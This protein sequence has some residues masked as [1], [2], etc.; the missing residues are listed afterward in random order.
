MVA[1]ALL[2]GLAGSATA[3]NVVVDDDRAECPAAG[4]TSVQAGVNAASSGDTVVICPG[5]Y[6]EGS[7]MPGTNAVTVDKEIDIR[8]AG[9]D[10]VTIMPKRSTASGGQIASITPVLRDPVGAIIAVTAGT[11]L[12]P[13]DVDISGVT[14]KGN[15]VFS[16]AGILYLDAKGKIFRSRVTD[17]VSSERAEAYDIPGGFRSSNTGYGIVQ[18]TAAATPPA[19]GSVPRTLV[20]ESTRVDKYN[21]TGILIDGATGDSLPLT[22]A[23]VNN[24]ADIVASM[25][26]GRLRCI[27]F[28]S[29]GNCATVGTLT[30]GPLFGQDGLRVTAGASVDVTSSSFFQNY[31]NGTGAPVFNSAT[32]NANLSQAAGVRLIGAAPSTI[33]GSNIANNHFGAFNV[34]LDG[35]TANTAAPLS[36][37]NNWWGLRT[38]GATYNNGPAISP[39]TNPPQYENPVNGTAVAD[40]SCVAT[41]IQATPGPDTTVSNSDTVDFCP[42]RNGAQV[43]PAKGEQPILDA[44]LPMSDAGPAIGLSLDKTGYDRGD[45]AVLTANA[46]DDFAVAK[47]TFYDGNEVIGTSTLPPYRSEIQIPADAACASRTLSAIVEDST[48]QTEIA[49]TTLSVTGP[50]DCEEIP[51][52]PDPPALPTIDLDV[53][54]TIGSAG[55]KATAAVTAE[56]GAQSVVFYLGTKTICTDS[57]APFECQ[58]QPTGSD[59]GS[60]TVRAVV[61]D[62]LARTAE[63]SSPVTVSKFVPKLTLKVVK[64]GMKKRQITGSLVLPSGVTKEQ[65]CSSAGTATLNVRGAV[66]PTINRQ[67]KLN[68]NCAFKVTVP[69]GKPKKGK[70]KRKLTVKARYGGNT[71]L[72]SATTSRKAS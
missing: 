48:G 15:G 27:D 38:T 62:A 24:Q 2:L 30:T 60:Q 55:A 36:A 29:T 69:V 41:S 4:F 40:A 11:P 31:V 18:T 9:A 71:V 66:I 26:V 72:T 58:I 8:G 7:G 17:I 46:T 49:D 16:E 54:G 52:P 1:A 28:L 32:N 63:D 43:D 44:P 5:S 53:P 21:K 61:T 20:I 68:A 39:T 64:R 65:A 51:E 22:S 70:K 59:V 3:A 56:A 25:V 57:A 13:A 23:G 42:Y 19:G 34:G 47:V 50:N 12:Y 45:T 37:E 6:V 35:S 67:V 33:T 14:V 10:L